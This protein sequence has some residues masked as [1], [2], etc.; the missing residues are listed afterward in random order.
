MG[1][2]MFYGKI[3]HSVLLWIPEGGGGKEEPLVTLLYFFESA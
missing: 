3:A 1:Q 2:T